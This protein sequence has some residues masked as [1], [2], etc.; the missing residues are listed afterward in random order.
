MARKNGH[1][2]F[3]TIPS[4]DG[5]MIAA[6]SLVMNQI[7]LHG[8]RANPNC[9]A[10]VLSMMEQGILNAKDV[11]THTFPIDQVHEAFDTFINRKD[12]AVKVVIH[13]ND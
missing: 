3:I 5:Q 2:A 8:V 6:K 9:S 7:S 11:I 12:G 4:E 13:P 1:V 10:T